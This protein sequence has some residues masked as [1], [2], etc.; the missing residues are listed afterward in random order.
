MN[1]SNKSYSD[2]QVN[3]LCFRSIKTS[4]VILYLGNC[5]MGQIWQRLRTNSSTLSRHVD[6]KKNLYP[7][8]ESYES[9]DFTIDLNG[10][11][12]GTFFNQ[13]EQIGNQKPINNFGVFT[14]LI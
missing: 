9:S 13:I 4:S 10:C 7:Q 8:F 3:Q 12:F 5:V 14:F 11:F 6:T 1:D 2:S